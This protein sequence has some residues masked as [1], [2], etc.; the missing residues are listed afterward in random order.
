MG[1]L[2]ISSTAAPATAP[3]ASI[4]QLAAAPPA[5]SFV[6]PPACGPA[7]LGRYLAPSMQPPNSAAGHSLTC[8]PGPPMLRFPQEDAAKLSWT[9][10]AQ[11]GER[12]APTPLPPVSKTALHST[13]PAAVAVAGKGAPSAVAG[14]LYTP[15][16]GPYLPALPPEHIGSIAKAA[17]PSISAALPHEAAKLR[18]APAPAAPRALAEAPVEGRLFLAAAATPAPTLLPVQSAQQRAAA[19]APALGQPGGQLASA[20]AAHALIAGAPELAQIIRQLPG[21]SPMSAPVRATLVACC[22]PSGHMTGKKCAEQPGKLLIYAP[23]MLLLCLK[24]SYGD[25]QMESIWPTWQRQKS[26]IAKQ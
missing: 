6:P 9:P 12:P 25:W 2:N 23:G 10:A 19:P 15:E 13:A 20:L 4:E 21:G 7:Q 14:Q 1:S 26:S 11:P 22:G 18:F 5:T 3:A 17:L 24:I 16:A 8:A